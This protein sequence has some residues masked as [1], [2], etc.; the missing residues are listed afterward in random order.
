MFNKISARNCAAI[1]ESLS[2]KE[3]DIENDVVIVD[4]DLYCVDDSEPHDVQETA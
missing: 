3:G 4:Y 1:R 2:E